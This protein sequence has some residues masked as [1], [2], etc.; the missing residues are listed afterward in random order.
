MKIDD[1]SDVPND[2]IRVMLM[3]VHQADYIV[4][5]LTDILEFLSPPHV[6]C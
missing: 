3:N 4:N 1:E 6:A 2:L 5:E